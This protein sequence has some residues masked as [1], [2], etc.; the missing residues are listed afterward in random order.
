MKYGK[1]VA[2][3][4]RT[5]FLS[6]KSNVRLTSGQMIRI[7]REKRKWTQQDLA[8][9]AG[10]KQSTVSALEHDRITLGVDRAK[11]LAICFKVHPGLL[12]FPSWNFEESAA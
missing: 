7:L 10:L 11:V 9:A 1:E 12:A 4:L 5:E 3:A 2:K 8:E 6:A